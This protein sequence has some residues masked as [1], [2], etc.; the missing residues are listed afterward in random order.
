MPFVLNCLLFSLFRIIHTHL[1]QSKAV[2]HGDI[3][4]KLLI[5]HCIPVQCSSHGFSHLVVLEYG[6][7]RIEKALKTTNRTPELLF[8]LFLLQYSQKVS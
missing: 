4:G 2:F 1:V 5:D 7:V 8:Q 3:S 6:L